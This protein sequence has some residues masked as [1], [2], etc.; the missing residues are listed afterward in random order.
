MIASLAQEQR[1]RVLTVV[2]VTFLLA[3]AVTAQV[4]AQLIPSSD[5]VGREQSLVANVR[6]LE[7]QNASLR[8]EILAIQAQAR[9]LN[10]KVAANSSEAR[11]LQLAINAQKDFSGLTVATGPG[12]AVDLG[13]GVD[14]KIP[15]DTKQLW[16]VRYLDLQD[17]VN[18]LW[19]AGAEGISV[20]HQRVVPSSS[21]FV[22]GSDVLLNGVHLQSPYRLEA[23]GAPAHFNSV[24]GDDN[25]A[26]LSELRSRSQ[27]YGVR[28]SWSQ[29]DSLTLPAYDGAVINRYAVAGN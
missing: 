2:L 6:A 16:Q 23:I 21:F 9:D 22:A 1:V 27:Q 20:N 29:Q 14:P 26:S 7:D 19:A 3:T 13:D 15:G 12:I 17:V 10:S 8:A 11:Q 4:K 25:N 18:A 5:R 28:F 24:L